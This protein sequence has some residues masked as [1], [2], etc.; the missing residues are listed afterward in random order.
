M[1]ASR[2]GCFVRCTAYTCAIIAHPNAGEIA[3]TLFDLADLVALQE[4]AFLDTA[5]AAGSHSYRQR[6]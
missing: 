5:T 1:P 4:R 6:T 3:V 2:T